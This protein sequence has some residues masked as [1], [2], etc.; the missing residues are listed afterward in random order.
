MNY[1]PFSMTGYRASYLEQE[2][3]PDSVA[4]M[5]DRDHVSEVLRLGGF[6]IFN[7]KLQAWVWPRRRPPA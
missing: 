2:M 1:A 5:R 7:F 4:I 6:P 3:A